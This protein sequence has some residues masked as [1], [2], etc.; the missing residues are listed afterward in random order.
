MTNSQHQYL[1]DTN[2]LSA[3]IKQPQGKLADKIATLA[4]GSFCTSVIVA[5]ELRYGA[6]KKKSAHLSHKIEALLANVPVLPLTGE[7]ENHYAVLRVALEKRGQ[8]ISA[9]DMLISAHALAL[10]TILVTANHREFV[11]VPGLIIENWLE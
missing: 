1:L 3:L 11:R 2:I 9:H 10:G 5:C 7:V 6:A 8:P 4:D